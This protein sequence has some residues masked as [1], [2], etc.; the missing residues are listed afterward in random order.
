MMLLHHTKE[1]SCYS[2]VMNLLT[3]SLIFEFYWL[4]FDLTQLWRRA[5]PDLTARSVPNAEVAN[6]ALF[7]SIGNWSIICVS[8][9][10]GV[11]AA[12]I[13]PPTSM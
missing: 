3:H 4:R 5:K 7:E 9:F 6:I 1:N 8:T 11:N 10:V 12:G 2:R 13:M